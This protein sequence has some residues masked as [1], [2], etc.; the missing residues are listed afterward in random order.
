MAAPSA[1]VEQEVDGA[2]SFVPALAP[3]IASWTDPAAVALLVK[4]CAV[5]PAEPLP[6]D[7]PSPLAC[8][9][10]FSQSCEGHD[11]CLYVMEACRDRCATTCVSCDAPCVDT[12]KSCS[13]RC[14][15]AACRKA[16]AEQTAACKEVCI[17]RFDRCST[18]E[19]VKTADTC[20]RDE[21]RKWSAHHCSCKSIAECTKPCE[22]SNDDGACL[23]RCQARAPGCDVRYC[24]EGDGPGRPTED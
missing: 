6:G 18:S 19:C 12:C 13:A 20:A 3:P 5:Q 7:E 16:C 15:D 11:P 21:Y 2:S 10:P 14:K 22:S 17:T 23:D 8:A 1:S 24:M 4:D 9:A